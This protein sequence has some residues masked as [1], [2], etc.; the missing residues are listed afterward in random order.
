M[1][2][3]AGIY[4]IAAAHRGKTMT[5]F[6]RAAIAEKLARQRMEQSAPAPDALGAQSAEHSASGALAEANEKPA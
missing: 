4:G 2:V 3:P 6:I 1:R 5:D